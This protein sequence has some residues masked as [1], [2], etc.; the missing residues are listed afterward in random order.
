MLL[1]YLVYL[2]T[3]DLLLKLWKNQL[4][5]CFYFP[6]FELFIF[7]LHCFYFFD[8]F[9]FRRSF[10]IPKEY[11]S[12]LVDTFTGINAM[13]FNTSHNLS[14]YSK[15]FLK[16]SFLLWYSND[17]TSS[18]SEILPLM[19][20]KAKLFL[21]YYCTYYIGI[22]IFGIRKYGLKKVSFKNTFLLVF[23]N[24]RSMYYGCQN[25]QQGHPTFSS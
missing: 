3:G 12:C 25:F 21:H 11:F 9:S 19:K 20:F 16:K 14:H 24:E 22:P 5:C 17:L 1:L 15:L 13:I 23:L 7:L 4:F 2:E 18:K 8:D 6:F 10:T